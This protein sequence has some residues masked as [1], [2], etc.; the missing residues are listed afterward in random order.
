MDQTK[1][2]CLSSQQQI[3]FPLQTA[4]DLI[5]R[6]DGRVVGRIKSI[7]SEGKSVKEAIVGDEVAIS[8]EG[9]TVGRQLCEEDIMY[10]DIPECDCKPLKDSKLNVDNSPRPRPRTPNWRARYR[11]RYSNSVEGRLP[12]T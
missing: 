12:D 10:V 11:P 2:Q 8:V 3:T 6:H 5:L 1:C 9:V 7:Q 4:F